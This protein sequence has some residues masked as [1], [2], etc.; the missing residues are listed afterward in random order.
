[1]ETNNRIKV[2]FHPQTK[3]ENRIYIQSD[4]LYIQYFG[5]NKVVALR[6]I[7]HVKISLV[8]RVHTAAQNVRV[9]KFSHL[10]SKNEQGGL[11]RFFFDLDIILKDEVIQFESMGIEDGIELIKQL[12]Q[13]VEHF[14]D[15]LLILEAINKYPNK[16]DLYRYFEI[17]YSSWAKKYHLD[18]P[19][20]LDKQSLTILKKELEKNK[21]GN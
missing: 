16:V 11:G 8:T 4:Y 15:P 19:R 12:Y 3:E 21:R 5:Q 14:E 6:D 9:L 2:Y 20:K 10:F 13:E 18:N 17:N 7:L 1:M